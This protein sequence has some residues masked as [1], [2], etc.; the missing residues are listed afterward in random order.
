MYV[1]YFGSGNVF[2]SVY[3]YHFPV[4]N[5]LL[6]GKPDSE[7]KNDKRK[8]KLENEGDI[9]RTAW[10]ILTIE[11]NMFVKKAY[12]G[13]KVVKHSTTNSEIWSSNPASPNLTLPNLT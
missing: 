6:T 2:E 7:V 8:E 10:E 1:L 13:S 5:P 12:S 11:I 4:E 9:Y 3:L